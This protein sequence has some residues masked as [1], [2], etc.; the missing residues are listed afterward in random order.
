MNQ[1]IPITADITPSVAICD[2]AEDLYAIKSPDCAA[3]ICQRQPSLGFQAWIDALDMAVLPAA[4]LILRPDDVRAAVTEVCDMHRTPAGPQRDNLIDDI[5]VLAGTFAN[6]MATAH[7]RLRLA[8]VNTN[9]CCRFHID[10]V[11]ARLICT[12]RGTGTQ[13]GIS[14]DDIPPNDVFTVP[15]GAPVVLRGIDWPTRPASDLLHRSPPI[16]GTRETRFVLVLDPI[17]DPEDVT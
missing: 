9:A 15:T 5:V 2:R 12:Y 6:V 13:F 8:P 11:T 16:E 3:V 1:P 14:T 7:L 10:A 4:R 17:F